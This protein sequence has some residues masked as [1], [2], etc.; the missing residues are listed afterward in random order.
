[1]H[2]WALC[3]AATRWLKKITFSDCAVVACLSLCLSVR[4]SVRHKSV[5]HRIAKTTPHKSAKTRVLWCNRSLWNSDGITPNG[6]PNSGGV[7]KNCVFRPVENLPLWRLTAEN[8]CPSATVVRVHDGAL[9][10]EYAVSSTTLEVVE[11]RWS[12]LRSSWH[13]QGCLYCESLLMTRTA[14]HAR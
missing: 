8:L 11:V 10:E 12:Q 13:Q 7:G 1:M 3:R 14:S 5:K 2:S 9:A 6:A 4:L